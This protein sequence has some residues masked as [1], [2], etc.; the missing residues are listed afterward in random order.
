MMAEII[1]S[2]LV[3]LGFGGLAGFVIGYACK[4]LLKLALILIGV[5]FLASY[6]LAY[7]DLIEI[8]YNKIS[9]AIQKLAT[10]G[11]SLP[12]LLTTNIP[13]AGSFAIGFCLGFKIG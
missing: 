7:K 13:L 12:T 6:Y 10:K 1:N 9:A 8:D 2:L 3:Q 5:L 4:K 11:F